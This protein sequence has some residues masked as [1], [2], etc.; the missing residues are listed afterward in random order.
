[1]L[2]GVKEN[3]ILKAN[4]IVEAN[5]IKFSVE[6]GVLNKINNFVCKFNSM[7]WQDKAVEILETDCDGE[8]EEYIRDKVKAHVIN[9]TDLS[10]YTLDDFEF[11]PESNDNIRQYNGDS[12]DI[13]DNIQ[14]FVER[15]LPKEAIDMI[16]TFE[17]NIKEI[18]IEEVPLN[19][20]ISGISEYVLY[21]GPNEKYRGC[22][23]KIVKQRDDVASE[24]IEFPNKYRESGKIA[25]FWSKPGNIVFLKEVEENIGV[26]ENNA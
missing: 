16:K 10:S 15:I 12:I 14:Y 13:I 19:T 6:K 23:G 4:L 5:H 21:M 1:M 18:D 3:Q 9:K 17:Q 22:I 25:R 8:E 11:T 20:L 2:V 7:L 26:Q 24:L